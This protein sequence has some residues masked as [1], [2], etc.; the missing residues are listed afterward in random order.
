MFHRLFF[1]QYSR[2]Y[3]IWIWD[4]SIRKLYSLIIISNEC[5][6]FDLVSECIVWVTP[7]PSLEFQYGFIFLQ[8]LFV[9]L[10]FYFLFNHAPF[11][12]FALLLT[13]PSSVIELYSLGLRSITLLFYHLIHP[14]STQCSSF[15]RIVSGLLTLMYLSSMY[16]IFP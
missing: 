2:N 9:I 13:E 11:V 15:F 4:D 12:S 5:N 7:E 14:L 16:Q 1:A 8:A 10:E 3:T 6:L